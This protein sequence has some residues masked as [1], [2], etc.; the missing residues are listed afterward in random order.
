[1]SGKGGNTKFAIENVT[2]TRMVI[3]DSKIHILGSFLNIKISR[4][5]LCSLIMGSPAGK[6]YSK[7][8]V[9]TAGR[10]C[11]NFCSWIYRMFKYS[12]MI[13]FEIIGET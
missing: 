7:L 2:K 1:M 4:D 6:V 11:F 3:A 5:S 13:L 12:S 8:R 10:R 9:V